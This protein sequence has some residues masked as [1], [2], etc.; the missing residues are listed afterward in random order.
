MNEITKVLWLLIFI[1]TAGD[2]IKGCQ[3]S[4]EYSESRAANKMVEVKGALNR[5]Y[6][7]VPHDHFVHLNSLSESKYRIKRIDEVD[8]YQ[9]AKTGIYYTQLRNL[10]DSVYTAIKRREK[11]RLSRTQFWLAINVCINAKGEVINAEVVSNCPLSKYLSRKTRVR[12]LQKMHSMKFPP[13]DC[14]E[15][16]VY[17]QIQHQIYKHAFSDGKRGLKKWFETGRNR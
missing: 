10:Q 13:F 16:D 2:K 4:D 17:I 6:F 7:E 1:F 9:F 3:S 14:D 8:A 11:E 15:K 12:I 5:L